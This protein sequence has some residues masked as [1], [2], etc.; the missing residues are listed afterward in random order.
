[1]PYK[2]RL[3]PRNSTVTLEMTLG[4]TRMCTTLTL[5][6]PSSSF[7]FFFNSINSAQFLKQPL[8]RRFTLKPHA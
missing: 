1:M 6:F 4:M 8:C 7:F 2:I 3:A 5:Q